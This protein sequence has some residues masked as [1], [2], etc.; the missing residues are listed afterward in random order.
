[1]KSFCT[2]FAV[3]LACPPPGLLQSRI[4]KDGRHGFHSHL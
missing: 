1:M 2:L 3:R 4:L